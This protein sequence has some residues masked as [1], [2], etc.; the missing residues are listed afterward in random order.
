MA[1]LIAI[2]YPDQTA[3]SAAADRARQLEGDLAIESAAVAVIRRDREGNFR[4]TISHHAVETGATWGM[5][6]ELLFGLLFFVPVLGMGVGSGLSPLIRS[7]EKAG[8]D[9]EF[10]D[11]VRDMLLPGTSAVFLVV[12]DVPPDRLVKAIGDRSGTML[13]SPLSE[14][15]EADL[16]KELRGA[17]TA[18][19]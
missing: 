15:A 8:I 7:I 19:V 18:T 1:N 10:R 2:G 5:F 14:R 11:H 3:A 16:K 17:S 13:W 4:V 9:P 12:R 6:W